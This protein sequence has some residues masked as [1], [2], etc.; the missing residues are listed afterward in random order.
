MEESTVIC[1]YLK[2]F[3]TVFD[4]ITSTPSDI[5]QM[6]RQLITYHESE[7]VEYY[8]D[9]LKE[10]TKN[11]SAAFSKTSI[12]Y[13]L[14]RRRLI[15]FKG[16][17]HLVVK[18]GVVPVATNTGRRAL[19]L[20]FSIGES[21][22]NFLLNTLS[23]LDALCEYQD[24]ST[25][26]VVYT[27]IPSN[28]SENYVRF[29]DVL[30]DMHH[31]RFIDDDPSI[32]ASLRLH[33]NF[34]TTESLE[35]IQKLKDFILFIADYDEAI[36]YRLIKILA[37]S[38][39]HEVLEKMFVFLGKGRNGKGLFLKLIQTLCLGKVHTLS[40]MYKMRK[41]STSS[42]ES[43][44]LEILTAKA[45]L[46]EEELE[47]TKDLFDESYK[48]LVTG[49]SE[50]GRRLGSNSVT[51]KNNSVFF[52]A[53]NY[54][55]FQ[56]IQNDD[57]SFLNRVVFT[58][59]NNKFIDK[60][61]RP[62]DHTLI[63]E[64]FDGKGKILNF[65]NLVRLLFLELKNIE[66]PLYIPNMKSNY[67]RHGIFEDTSVK[68]QQVYDV[69]HE[70]QQLFE[71]KNRIQINKLALLLGWTASE[72]KETFQHEQE[73]T[74]KKRAHYDYL[75]L[76]DELMKRKVTLEMQPSDFYFHPLID[77][78]DLKQGA[79]EEIRVT[80]LMYECAV[81][82][83]SKIDMTEYL[84][85]FDCFDVR[86]YEEQP[87]VVYVDPKATS[88]L[89]IL[90]SF[91]MEPI[92]KPEMTNEDVLNFFLNNEEEDI[93]EDERYKVSVFRQNHY[94]ISN[95]DFR[96]DFTSDIT[97]L[98]SAEGTEKEALIKLFP[99]DIETRGDYIVPSN[100][101]ALDF[102]SEKNGD[103]LEAI[104]E[105]FRK[106]NVECFVQESTSS[107]KNGYIKFHII[108]YCNNLVHQTRYKEIVEKFAA[109]LPFEYDTNYRYRTIMNVSHHKWYH[110]K[111]E[112][113]DTT[114]FPDREIERETITLADGR[115][116][117]QDKSS[118]NSL[119]DYLIDSGHESA[120]LF[121][122]VILKD[123]YD[124]GNRD[125]TVFKL[126]SYLND[127]LLNYNMKPSVYLEGYEILSDIVFKHQVSEGKGELMRKIDKARIDVS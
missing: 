42:K 70:N 123:E 82:G 27:T 45:T 81:E 35:A 77:V 12:L 52:V 120:G 92:E 39:T 28:Y 7:P 116:I 85:C 72:I 2:E 71:K 14:E 56:D 49:G 48:N 68:K 18:S 36:Y 117:I 1:R 73:V 54:S 94:P 32:I 78:E 19:S 63:T 41:S 66:N 88:N 109:R 30:I 15:V 97:S 47:F 93:V 57:W 127:S 111:G 76:T 51:L 75:Q 25:G 101:L 31:L 124:T 58:D 17:L 110:I 99:Y 43:E 98:Q 113:F 8:Y 95:V 100:L 55:N 46:V 26:N 67:I 13:L 121:L 106:L 11:K 87:F 10:E 22:T 112:L 83:V 103:D 64:I 114:E 89:D 6:I 3:D 37:Y 102:D 74:I 5:H 118:Y 126:T 29:N 40:S 84:A 53:T 4:Y 60:S 50:T 21:E 125:D 105:T 38:Y 96:T 80:Q 24:L 33:T 104:L 20:E 115:E 79:Q 16:S 90:N 23:T 44:I 61:I 86:F 108:V 34:T 122:N 119:T 59:F 65:V 91:L 69:L 107:M 62:S 9:K